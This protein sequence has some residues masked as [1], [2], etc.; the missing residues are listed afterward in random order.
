MSEI[1]IGKLS[2][3]EEFYKAVKFVIENEGLEVAKGTTIEQ[4]EEA[5]FKFYK[6]N[7]EE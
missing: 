1:K 3:Y 4:L 5:I 6:E 2:K 7:T